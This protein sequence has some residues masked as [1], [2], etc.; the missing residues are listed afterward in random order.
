MTCGPAMLVTTLLALAW[1]S[2]ALASDAA[3]G[4]GAAPERSRGD[5]EVTMRII[6]DPDAMDAAAITRRITLPAPVAPVQEADRSPR[7]SAANGPETSQEARE[8]GR[9]FGQ[10][11]AERARQM[12]EQAS[13]QREEFGRSR[14]E[15]MRPDPPQPPKPPQ[16][17]G[18]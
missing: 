8:R 16:P 9:E 7:E 5:L 11:T 6:E 17:P 10:E 1:S 2:A 4:K 15:E 3:A 13:E 14:A 12:A 18:P